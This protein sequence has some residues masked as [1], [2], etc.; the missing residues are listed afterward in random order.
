MEA[1]GVSKV[2]ASSLSEALNKDQNY[3]LEKSPQSAEQLDR[4]M[5]DSKQKYE[6]PTNQFL[7][8]IMT[9]NQDVLSDDELKS[10]LE[11]FHRFFCEPDLDQR[12][13][14]L[15]DSNGTL[16]Q[17]FQKMQ[18]QFGELHIEC[19]NR[20]FC[21]PD[22]KELNRKLTLI[23]FC[24]KTSFDKL[25]LGKMLEHA[26][27][28]DMQLMLQELTP[29]AM[30]QEFDMKDLQKHQQLIYFYLRKASRN[31]YRKIGDK[32]YKP[33]YNAQNQFVYCY[34]YVCTISDFLF[35][36]LYPLEQN[37]YWFQCLT[38]KPGISKC[39]IDYLTLLHT[40]WLPKLIV[41]KNITSFQ[42]GLF[43]LINKQFY[44]FESV[45]ELMLLEDNVIAPEYHDF[46][47]NL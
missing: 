39:V 6:D 15:Y 42:N 40:E 44:K 38:E 23:A 29:E 5:T 31:Q 19:V 22:G 45:Q 4:M 47:L 20:G 27:E 11:L 3:I 17:T 7:Q 14:A 36:S 25:I 16:K 1:N 8:R 12:I 26:K 41:N 32:L 24:I 35:E 30:F 9:Y 46:P 43:Y 2:Y 10:D 37:H 13:N 33:K 28:P 21:D 34:E 18:R